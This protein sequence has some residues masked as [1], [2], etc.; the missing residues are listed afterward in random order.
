MD[1]DHATTMGRDREGDNDGGGGGGRDNT[2]Q[3]GMT[4]HPRRGDN[5][6]ED[7]HHHHRTPNCCR[8]QLLVGWKWA[9][10]TMG[11]GER[12]NDEGTMTTIATGTTA[13]ASRPPPHV[14]RRG[15]IFSFFGFNQS[16]P[17]LCEGGGFFDVYNCSTPL[18]KTQGRSMYYLTKLYRPSR[19]CGKKLFMFC[20]YRT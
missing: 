14:L 12:D 2:T 20:R 17:H 4:L 7:G 11:R 19:L 16:P 9:A 10:T 1:R 5:E 3:A 8:E 18:R 15:G 13:A 6:D